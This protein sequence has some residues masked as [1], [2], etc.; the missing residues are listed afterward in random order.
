MGD[1]S[2]LKERAVARTV[3]RQMKNPGLSRCDSTNQQAVT[4]R[5]MNCAG[6]KLCPALRLA[7]GRSHRV[8]AT[9]Q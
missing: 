3:R 7:R 4:L 2:R 5:V 1:H 6:L 9:L 8:S